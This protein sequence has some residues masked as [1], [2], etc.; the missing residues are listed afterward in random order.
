MT[1][2]WL[3]CPSKASPLRTAPI[4]GQRLQDWVES[5]GV[6]LV[7]APVG[8][9]VCIQ[10]T[11]EWVRGTRPTLLESQKLVGYHIAT[12]AWRTKGN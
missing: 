11:E 9:G 8:W 3:E 12:N 1:S 2:L 6:S 4:D 10:T 5:L 7:W